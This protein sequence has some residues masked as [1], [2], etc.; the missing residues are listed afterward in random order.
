M[1][2]MTSNAAGKVKPP[3]CQSSSM[4]Q[5]RSG[6]KADD[7]TSKKETTGIIQS[8]YLGEFAAHLK[9]DR[10]DL[11][12]AF[13]AGTELGRLSSIQRVADETDEQGR[14]ALICRFNS[15]KQVVY[16]PRGSESDQQFCQSLTALSGQDEKL[17][18]CQPPF[19][20]REQYGWVA[21]AEQ[22]QVNH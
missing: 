14:F 1:Y 18:L 4:F 19:I 22:A 17:K 8:V 7:P 21:Y 12:Q 10:A 9:A 6:L 5:T 20:M 3:L 16:K 11:Q 13:F 2:P 15:G